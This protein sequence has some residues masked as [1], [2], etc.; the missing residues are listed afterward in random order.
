[1][2]QAS[3]NP[4]GKL[5]ENHLRHNQKEII[6]RFHDGSCNILVAT[7]VLEEGVDVRAC[8]LVVRFDG[9]K[10][11]C[12]YVQSK[13]RARSPNALYILMVPHEEL[14]DFLD[15]LASFHAIEQK[16]LNP[17]ALRLT[18][19]EPEDPDPE[20]FW[21]TKIKPYCPY[22]NGPRITLLSAMGLLNW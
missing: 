4:K 18:L 1:M 22:P 2:G 17:A 16:L 11:Y 13:G 20:E 10:T 21:N 15:V 6:R 12:D 7:S 8:N 14:N 3:G 9:I 19:D 5:A